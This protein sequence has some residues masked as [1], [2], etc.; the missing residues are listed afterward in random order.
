[1][2]IYEPIASALIG[3]PLQHT[4]ERL[5]W[6]SELPRRLKHP[7]LIEIFLENDRARAVMARTITEDMNCIDIG[8][9]LG[10]VLNE[11]VR[12]SPKGSHIAVEPIPYKAAWLR[13]KYP[14]V[15]VHQIALNDED[16][17]DDFYYV[18]ERSGF[19]GL[20]KHGLSEANTIKV[21]C[22]RLDDVVTQEMPIGF[23]KLDVEGCE[24]WVLKG[25]ERVLSENQVVLLFECTNSGL[26][27]FGFRAEQVYSC[28]VDD[29]RYRIFLMK[30]WL[31][32]GPPLDLS[33]FNAS[34]IYPF[35]AFSYIA[36]PQ[37]LID[38]R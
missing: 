7:E 4:A 3:T 2:R 20:R 8:C 34:M 9:H 26:D 11:F 21:Q 12:L 22:K 37:T 17:I 19:S 35:K 10:S 23:I 14:R 38:K 6:I 18:P 25:A 5:R 33:E 36:A 1:V 29:F 13:R 30:D 24:Y 27:A 28:L 15:E 32:G 16:S 31:S